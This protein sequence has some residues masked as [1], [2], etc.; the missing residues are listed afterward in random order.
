MAQ[1][2]RP[3]INLTPVA[4]R[5]AGTRERIVE[6]HFPDGRG[7]LISLRETDDGVA[8]ID[9]Y[10]QDAGLVVRAATVPAGEPVVSPEDPALAEY[11]LRLRPPWE[12]VARN[13]AQR[14]LAHDLDG[15]GILREIAGAHGIALDEGGARVPA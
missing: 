5:Y 12:A 10:R 14:M 7:C 11:G 4:D 6:V 3:S 13:M 9:V 2:N 15:V 1:Q 8:T